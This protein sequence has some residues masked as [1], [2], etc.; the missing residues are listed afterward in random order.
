MLFSKIKHHF[1]D[2][3]DPLT[4][5]AIIDAH[6]AIPI[7][8]YER[9]GFSD[10]AVPILDH[11]LRGSFLDDV[12]L[13]SIIENDQTLTEKVVFRCLMQLSETIRVSPTPVKVLFSETSDIE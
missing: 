7:Q 4:R 11:I 3:P 8:F 12:D 13:E 2:L 1:L 6:E 10:P 9:T 5:Q